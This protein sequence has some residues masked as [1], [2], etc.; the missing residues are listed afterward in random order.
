ME[1]GLHAGQLGHGDHVAKLRPM[2]VEALADRRVR[3]V[4]TGGRH[5]LIVTAAGELYACGLNSWGQLGLGIPIVGDREG[6]QNSRIFVPLRVQG[7]LADERVWQASAGSVHSVVVTEAG[8]L[9]AMG[10]N[11]EGRLGLGSSASVDG[12]A[13]FCTRKSEPTLVETLAGTPVVDVAAGLDHTL[14]RSAD[15]RIFSWGSNE[16]GQTGLGRRAADAGGR[17]VPSEIEVPFRRAE[18]ES[19]SEE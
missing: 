13:P 11:G 12:G 16:D 14:A 3:S 4:D 8:E 15:G 2:R 5:T 7:R 1:L 18:A 6:A 19:D 10:Y 17:H 9:Y